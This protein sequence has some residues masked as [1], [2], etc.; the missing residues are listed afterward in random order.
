[1]EPGAGVDVVANANDLQSSERFDLVLC[2]EVLEHDRTP[3]DT[4]ATCKRSMRNDGLLI[5]TTPANGFPDHKY[6][7]DY[8]RFMPDAYTDLFFAG[9]KVLELLEIDGPTLCGAATIS[10]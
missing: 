3:L 5:I 2:C 7:R 4:V 1:L 6:P 10:Q 9:M 8:W